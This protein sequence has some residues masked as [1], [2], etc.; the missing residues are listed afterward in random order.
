VLEWA[1]TT[2]RDRI[3]LAC[4]FGGPSG[5][6]LVDMIARAGHPVPVYYLDTDLL[7]P[8]TYALV[9]RVRE[10]Y[11]I[12]PIAVKT[13]LDLAGQARLHGDKLWERDPDACCALR[14][15]AP[16]RAFLSK[17][18]AW[19]TGIR[20]DQA[21]TRKDTPF[22]S[23]DEHSGGLAKVSPLADWTE[24]D[25]WAYVVA[26]DVPYNE[27][28]DQGFPSVGCVPCTRRAG[29]GENPRAG[30]WEGFEK[31]EC[32]LHAPAEST[33]NRR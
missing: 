16:Q 22:V 24:K 29:P 1:A 25:V 3:V 21:E 10:R 26:H 32:G 17:Y 5:M 8:E 28:H 11:G 30:R 31:T 6:V 20:R 23:W 27:L 14:K 4:S 13:E 18:G 9:E 19:I 12:Q 15:V 33:E 7:F 2:Y